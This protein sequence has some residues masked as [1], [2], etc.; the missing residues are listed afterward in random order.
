MW[1]SAVLRLAETLCEPH[2]LAIVQALL[3]ESA[4]GS[5]GA[6][7]TSKTDFEVARATGLSRRLVRARCAALRGAGLVAS[8]QR[9]GEQR[10]FF[11]TELLARA[12]RAAL[13][14]FGG[15]HEGESEYA[16]CA[17]CGHCVRGEDL[18]VLFFS[19][20]LAC[21][22]CGREMALEADHAD[23]AHHATVETLRAA[24]ETLEADPCSV[25]HACLDSDGSCGPAAGPPQ[26]H[27]SS[28]ASRAARAD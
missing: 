4:T 9:Q 22:L 18:T 3:A 13:A 11:D 7:M 23:S 17:H 16:A 1:R 26:P 10:Y 5:A 14:A 21:P 20:E 2:D 28:S 24:A 19:G 12:M 8:C 15:G 6:S 27:C 25:H